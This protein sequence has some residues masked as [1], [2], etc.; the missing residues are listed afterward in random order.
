MLTHGTR[1][2]SP[3]DRSAAGTRARSWRRA[4]APVEQPLCGVS[5]LRCAGAAD[6]ESDSGCSGGVPPPTALGRFACAARCA[7]A[8]AS[9]SA[10]ASK[11]GRPPLRRPD[12]AAYYSATERH[13]GTRPQRS[14]AHSASTDRPWYQA[15]GAVCPTWCR[16]RAAE[17]HSTPVRSAQRACGGRLRVGSSACVRLP[18]RSAE[19]E[20]ELNMDS[21]AA[22]G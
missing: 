8:F 9:H 3:P 12:R 14:G 22:H 1:A 18:R 16:T 17:S 13:R 7:K 15:G 10:A 5:A 4:R 11:A 6:S 19:A 20:P 21:D 2:D